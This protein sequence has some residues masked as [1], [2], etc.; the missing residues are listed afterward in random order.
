MTTHLLLAS[1]V[2]DLFVLLR[3]YDKVTENELKDKYLHE[4]VETSY[5]FQHDTKSRLSELITELI[6]D[7]TT[8]V[9]GGDSSRAMNELKS[10]QREQVCF[11]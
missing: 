5:P 10:Y 1:L 9:T 7:Y 11:V 4:R 2:S 3:R 6:S 8:C